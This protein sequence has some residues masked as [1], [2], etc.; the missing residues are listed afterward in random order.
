MKFFE[1][2]LFYLKFLGLKFEY[3]GYKGIF[4]Q[5]YFWFTI[6]ALHVVLPYIIFYLKP[7]PMT[8][9]ELCDFV[10]SKLAGVELCF[11]TMSIYLKRR[12]FKEFMD[13][14][15]KLKK[16]GRICSKLDNF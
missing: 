12:Q 1:Q 13:V 2:N 4:L 8:Y 5:I 6:L 16:S 9:V 10:A 15:E 14:L 3:S 7:N 11:M